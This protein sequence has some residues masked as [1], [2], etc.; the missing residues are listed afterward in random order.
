MASTAELRAA[1]GQPCTVSSAGWHEQQQLDW[2][3]HDAGAA[4]LLHVFMPWQV[5]E[6]CRV[7][8][9]YYVC[10]DQCQ[11]LP[12]GLHDGSLVSSSLPVMPGKYC[13]YPLQPQAIADLI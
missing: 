12:C 7:L 13:Q 6:W 11:S 2:P 5:C 10:A 8:D 4:S 9:V 3:V 1:A